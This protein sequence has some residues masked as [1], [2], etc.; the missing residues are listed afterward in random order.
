[1][2]EIEG[3]FKLALQKMQRVVASLF[4]ASCSYACVYR[5]EQAVS[6]LPYTYHNKPHNFLLN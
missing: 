3:D 1:M 5:T 6:S 4:N 2:Q